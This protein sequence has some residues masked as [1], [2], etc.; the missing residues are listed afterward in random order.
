LIDT[1]CPAVAPLCAEL[2]ERA[3]ALGVEGAYFL[4][5][6]SFEPGGARILAAASLR[7]R[8]LLEA[9]HAGMQPEV[10]MVIRSGFSRSE[11]EL[12]C[13]DTLLAGMP[14]SLRTARQAWMDQAADVWGVCLRH[15]FDAPVFGPGGWRGLFK[16]NAPAGP[17]SQGFMRAVQVSAERFHR[18]FVRARSPSGARTLTELEAGAL[19]LIAGGKCCKQAAPNLGVSAKAAEKALERARLKLGAGNTTQAALRAYQLGLIA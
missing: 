10:S 7:V 15:G 11:P 8:P 17:I 2:D 5:V 14:S 9:Y 18:G 4:M 1:A 16:I 3:G 6:P 12:W 19:R 13:P